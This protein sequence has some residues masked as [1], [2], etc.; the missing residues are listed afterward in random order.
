MNGTLDVGSSNN[1]NHALALSSVPIVAC[2]SGGGRCYEFSLDINQDKHSP[3]LSLDD[4][5]IFTSNTPNQSVETF[6]NGVVDING[7]LQYRLDSNGQ[8]EVV[9]D[10][11]LNPG[12]GAGDMN[13][14]VPYFASN[15]QYV[16]LYSHFGS[17]SS[18]GP[19]EAANGK[20]YSSCS[21]NDGFEEWYVVPT[22]VP[23]PEPATL[24]LLGTG[25]VGLGAKLRRRM[26]KA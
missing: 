8:N 14:F 24:V 12:S 21:E 17:L 25:L 2:P 15:D 18:C 1:F 11:L 20:T 3:L 4:V 19:Y 13:M 23:V 10:Y 16:Y 6:T 26:K 22:S 5:Q 9:L 7:A